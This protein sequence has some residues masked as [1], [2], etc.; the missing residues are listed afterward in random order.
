MR[1]AQNA[2]TH[3][4]KHHRLSL[5]SSP[6]RSSVLLVF[7]SDMT[8]EPE[9]EKWVKNVEFHAAKNVQKQATP[10]PLLD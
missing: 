7:A 3:A 8:L 5:S 10:F 4:L 1:R 9:C 6:L 2:D